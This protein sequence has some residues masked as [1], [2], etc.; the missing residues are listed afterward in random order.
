[1]GPQKKSN[2]IE[3]IA[4]VLIAIT[5]T[6]TAA[7]VAYR[8]FA[9]PGPPRASATDE[10]TFVSEWED[11]VEH[12]VRVGDPS[13]AVQ[14][15]TFT[16]LECPFCRRFH[17][18]AKEVAETR[19]DVAL[20]WLHFPLGRHRFAR[21]AAHA[22]ECAWD[23]GRFAEFLDVVYERQDS[24]GLTSW[25]EFAALAGVTD[26]TRF[27]GCIASDE[28]P[29]RIQLGLDA[30]RRV[31]ATG[32]PTV[33]INGWRVAPPYTTRALEQAIDDVVEREVPEGS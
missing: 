6:V 1:M 10:P 9:P 12:G 16:D 14:I 17:A 19:G 7:A 8:T 28:P 5:S 23:E 24:L 20:T 29:P 26:T 18:V 32:T 15:V 2:R 30:A 25:L 27:A 33:L 11:L 31:G 22:A 21:P 3:T 4:F 13:A